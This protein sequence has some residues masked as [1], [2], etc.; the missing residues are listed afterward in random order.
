MYEAIPTI[1]TNILR[2]YV[3]YRFMK[4]FF[5]KNISS[6]KKMWLCYSLFYVIT[7]LGHLV[8]HS[9]T[10]NIVTNIVSLW[11]IIG[12]YERKGLKKVLVMFMIYSLN[13]V[14]DFL[15]LHLLSNY[16]VTKSLDENI[17]YYTVFLFL[18]CEIITEKVLIKNKGKGYTPYK[19]I[20]VFISVIGII[21]IYF[22]E[23]GMKNRAFLTASGAGIL[24]I[25]LLVFYLYDVLT[26]AYR[27]LE[28]QSL[29]EK[30]ILT[31]SNQLDVLAR[32][33]EKVAAFRH[34]M[35]NH[36]ADLAGM[37]K[38]QKNKEIEAYIQEMGMYMENPEEFVSTGNKAIDSLMNYLLGQ[39]KE[40]LQEV[41]YEIFIP[42]ELKISAFNMNVIL[43]NLIENAIEA[44]SQSEDK[45]LSIRISYEKGMLFMN[46]RNSFSHELNVQNHRFISTKKEEEHG[47][48]LQ[49]VEKMVEQY[50]GT[51][52]I[53]NTKNVF[54]VDVILYV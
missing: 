23:Y 12:C 7:A 24:L 2:A 26:E 47:I 19:N 36:L 20:M 21:L 22:A 10:V 4:L 14:C 43:G 3:L 31:Y 51:M 15:C 1:T 30:Q 29:L 54:E 53:T 38:M 33:E 8:I 11:L 6:K 16:S 41:D 40:Q 48:G 39:A 9:R 18:I 49:N 35:K 42:A 46:I 45:W 28:E 44:S 13:I 37:A 27:K 52:E 34:D 17:A 32:S 25:E 5:Q 50:H